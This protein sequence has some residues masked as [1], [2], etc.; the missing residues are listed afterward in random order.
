MEVDTSKIVLISFANEQYQQSA[1]SLEK[2]AR[3]IGF[4]DI[5]LFGPSDLSADFV[6]KHRKTL[7]FPRGAGY[8]LWKPWIIK[9]VLESIDENQTLLYCDAGVTLRSNA[10]YFES[11]AEDG[12]IHL[13]SPI[14]QKQ[15][16]NYWIDQ[17]VWEE[18]V[19][20]SRVNSDIHYWAGLILSQ[21]NESFRKIVNYWLG[22]C[23]NEHLLCP[24][25]R[26]KYFPSPGLIAHRHDQSLLNCIVVLRPNSFSLSSF[27]ASSIRS[28]FLIHR[29]GNIKTYSQAQTLWY[30][31]KAY[32]R[33][34]QIIP[35]FLR[36]KLYKRITKLRRPY[37]SETEIQRHIDLFF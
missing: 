22:L 2:R 29:R 28:P 16:N 13:W 14:S 8:W 11:L 32:S 9:T 19:G 23:A 24:D 10:D 30:I 18:V 26:V 21:K 17:K 25:S 1:K 7:E 12:K 4:S 36:L 37:A 6:A 34:M 5:R 31:Q 33:F 15:T 35:K 3:A 20:N 27:D